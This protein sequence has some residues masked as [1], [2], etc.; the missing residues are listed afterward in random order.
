MHALPN[1]APTNVCALDDQDPHAG[2]ACHTYAIQ[3]GGPTDVCRVQ[4]QH[5]PRGVEGS[6][7]GVFDDDLLAIVEDRL[8]AFQSG[9]YCCAENANALC[10]VREARRYLGHRVARRASQGVLGANATHKS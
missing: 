4:F 7:A 2:N 10:A 9:P 5:G 1:M 3:Y 6:T 8:D